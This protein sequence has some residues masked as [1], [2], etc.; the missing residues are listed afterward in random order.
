M[1]DTYKGIPSNG[2]IVWE[3]W[4]KESE[5]L[6]KNLY[7]TRF[8]KKT[9]HVNELKELFIKINNDMNLFHFNFNH[10]DKE[11]H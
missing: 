4:M 8:E 7:I 2:T 1:Q 6:L 10:L 5:T 11:K 9:N 3:D